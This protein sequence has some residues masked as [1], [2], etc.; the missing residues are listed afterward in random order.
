MS[1][2]EID[3]KDKDERMSGAFDD[4]KNEELVKAEEWTSEWDENRGRIQKERMSRANVVL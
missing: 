2:E 1:A 3:D 4:E